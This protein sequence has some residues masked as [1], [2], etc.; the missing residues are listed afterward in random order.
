MDER[1][2]CAVSIEGGTANA[3]PVKI[4]PWQPIDPPDVEQNLFPAALYGVDH[5]D[6]HA[7]I[8][9]RPQLAAVE[10][11]GPAFDRA[12]QAIHV[13]YQQR[14]APEK[15]ST[16]SSDDAHSWTPKMRLATTDWFCRWFYGRKGPLTEPEFETEPPEALYCTADGSIRYSQT[17]Q[18]I[19]SLILNKQADLPPVRSVPKTSTERGAYQEEIRASISSLLRYQ[20][21]E[22][23][24]NVRHTGTT[25]RE[26]YRIEK[27]QFL[28]EPGIY[29]PAWVYVPDNKT[30]VLPAILYVNDGGM[31]SD[32]MEFEGE[33]GSGLARGIL[34]TLV[35][36][37]NLVVAVDVRGIGETRPLHQDVVS[38]A[39]SVFAGDP[40]FN[41]LSDVETAMAYMAWYM[42]QSLLGMRVQDVVRSVDYVMS[43]HDADGDH[44]HV[45]GKGMG[46]L[47]CLYATALDPRIRSL[48]S[49]RS[50]VSYRCLTQVDRYVYGADV[51]VPDVLL[52]FDLPQVAAAIVGRPLALVLPTDAMKNTMEM[53]LAQETY[54]WTQATYKAADLQNLFKIECQG[55]DLES[56]KHYLSLIGSFAAASS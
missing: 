46:A 28:S 56:A 15:F 44:L 6:L 47:W 41:Q 4:S 32:G 24:L 27:I 14:S 21:S 55:E 40:Q 34:D 25:P 10:R 12:A 31:E 33:E 26:G 35:L 29:I 9:P 37:G 38:R 49:V 17:G 52:H 19:F 3:W 16:A 13:R 23:P 22:Q 50:L 30:G 1:V 5:V 53:S 51:F 39:S 54:K 42:D 18:T 11:Y 8:A 7:A 36:A 2:Q 45:I 43:R 20:K 48:I